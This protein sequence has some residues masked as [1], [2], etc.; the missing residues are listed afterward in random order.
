VSTDPF[1]ADRNRMAREQAGLHR[2]I[3]ELRE[4]IE[5]LQEQDRFHQ[6]RQLEWIA[7]EVRLE[8]ALEAANEA[9]EALRAAAER[10]SAPEVNQ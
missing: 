3:E 1:L 9:N 8:M 7:K 10:A 5:S 2:M 6:D 4:Q